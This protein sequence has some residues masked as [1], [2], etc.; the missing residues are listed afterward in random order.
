[1]I[2]RVIVCRTLEWRRIRLMLFLPKVVSVFCTYNLVY[3]LQ[4]FRK[5]SMSSSIIEQLPDGYCSLIVNLNFLEFSP[6]FKLIWSVLF[7]YN[8]SLV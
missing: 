3:T 2:P 7:H 1:M 5:H 8:L 6:N 4:G